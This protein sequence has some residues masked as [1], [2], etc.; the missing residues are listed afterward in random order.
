MQSYESA[1]ANIQKNKELIKIV[2]E[3]IYSDG[4]LHY[5][6]DIWF[7]FRAVNQGIT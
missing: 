5:F 2:D 1:Y 3:L 7:R 6:V 4:Y